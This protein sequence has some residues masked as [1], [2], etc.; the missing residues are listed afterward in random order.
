[1]RM[2]CSLSLAAVMSRAILEAPTMRPVALRT[3]EMGQRYGHL[4]AVLALADCFV[5]LDAFAAADAL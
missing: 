3:G 4:L 1:M 2:R 5:A